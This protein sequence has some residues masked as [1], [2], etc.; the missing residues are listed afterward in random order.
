V[1]SVAAGLIVDA[2]RE[3]MDVN[4]N[5]RFPLILAR[6]RDSPYALMPSLTLY[7]FHFSFILSSSILLYQMRSTKASTCI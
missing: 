5:G 1:P 4:M 7:L 3:A 2:K 6:A